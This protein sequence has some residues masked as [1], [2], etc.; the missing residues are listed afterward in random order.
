[1]GCLLLQ[2]HVHV[3]WWYLLLCSNNV[4]KSEEKSHFSH[5]CNEGCANWNI[6]WT[7]ALGAQ[8]R[9]KGEV[10]RYL[11]TLVW[12]EVG[13]DGRWAVGRDFGCSGSSCRQIEMQRSQNS[14]GALERQ[15]LCADCPSG[16]SWGKNSWVKPSFP[17]GWVVFYSTAYVE[18]VSSSEKSLLSSQQRLPIKGNCCPQCCGWVRRGTCPRHG[19]NGV[20]RRWHWA[21][22]RAAWQGMCPARKPGLFL[23]PA[24]GKGEHRVLWNNSKDTGSCGGLGGGMTPF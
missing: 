6:L 9:E 14:Q 1:M 17:A 19:L 16:W 15:E 22:P 3:E 2:V 20:S 18:F 4:Y 10:G 12:K 8:G 13:W 21:W 23:Q 7:L 11:I 24:W 5:L